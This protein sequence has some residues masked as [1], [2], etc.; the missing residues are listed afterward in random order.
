M[1]ATADTQVVWV[2]E[3]EEFDR[4]GVECIGASPEAVIEAVKAPYVPPYIVAWSVEQDGDRWVLVGDFEMVP[5]KSTEHRS[6][7][8]IYTQPFVG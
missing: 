5:G 2:A 6:V 8:T 4:Y 1:T 3:A 7:W